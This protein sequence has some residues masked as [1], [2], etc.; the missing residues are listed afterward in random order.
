MSINQET[1][2]KTTIIMKKR[3]EQE[4]K[5]NAHIHTT[6]TKE[7]K[8]KTKQKTNQFSTRHYIHTG[9]GLEGHNL[10][11]KKKKTHTQ[12]RER[13]EGEGEG[14]GQETHTYICTHT[15][16]HTCLWRSNLFYGGCG[17]RLCLVALHINNNE[18]NGTKKI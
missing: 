7:R 10:R 6:H 12:L 18:Q 16:T 9:R 15:H 14:N 3:V 17:L 4:R 13:G 5:M 8:F 1:K 2:Q 11:D